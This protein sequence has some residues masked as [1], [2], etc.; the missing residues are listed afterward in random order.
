[1]LLVTRHKFWAEKMVI[2]Q[3]VSLVMVL[4][5]VQEY[6][7]FLIKPA[8]PEIYGDRSLLEYPESRTRGEKMH[9]RGWWWPPAF[10]LLSHSL[11]R[12]W[13]GINF[14]RI[15]YAEGVCYNWSWPQS[16]GVD[17]TGGGS[18]WD[19][20]IAAVI[21]LASVSFIFLISLTDIFWFYLLISPT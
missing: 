1:M 20:N 14:V 10:L 2:T 4:S 5:R 18:W 7:H 21:L 13:C 11:W 3:S 9:K 17:L 8:G 12:H 15:L 19:V 6:H 16:H